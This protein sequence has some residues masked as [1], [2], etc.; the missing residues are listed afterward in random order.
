[1]FLAIS[2]VCC[3]IG[4]IIKLT[5]SQNTHDISLASVIRTSMDFFYENPIGRIINRFTKDTDVLDDELGRV[6]NIEGYWRCWW[7]FVTDNDCQQFLFVNP[8]IVIVTDDAVFLTLDLL[9][10]VILTFITNWFSI[11]LVVPTIIL[12]IW[13]RKGIQ[14]LIPVA[15]NS[16]KRIERSSD[17]WNRQK[18]VR[19][20][21]E[22]QRIEGILRSPVNTCY[23][24]TIT[25]RSTIDAYKIQVKSYNGKHWTDVAQRFQLFLGLYDWKIQQPTK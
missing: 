25:G 1:M 15:S 12:I 23:T 9:T 3:L 16:Q 8:L 11:L 18:Y 21:R 6:F 22:V 20:S 13:T 24:E 2:M 5:T 4:V 10:V 14:G 19:T 17:L 7:R